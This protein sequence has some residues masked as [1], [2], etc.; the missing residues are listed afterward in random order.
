[1]ADVP[2]GKYKFLRALVDSGASKSIICAESLPT[3]TRKK[4]QPD[5]EGKVIWET[6]G[7]TN[8]T[9]GVCQVW[10]QLTEFAPSRNFKHTFKVDSAP[11]THKTSYDIILGRD[12]MRILQLDLLFSSSIPKYHGTLNA[13]MTASQEVIGAT[14]NFEI[15]F[16]NNH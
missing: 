4:I 5:P 13:L 1:M 11:K 6:K 12:L 16:I 9:T 2:T 8:K 10:F 3:H 15:Y 14:T 7:G